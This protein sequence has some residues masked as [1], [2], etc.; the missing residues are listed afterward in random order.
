MKDNNLIN[1]SF[2]F[3]SC[4]CVE[5]IGSCAAYVTTACPHLHIIKGK[6]VTTKKECRKC[7]RR[8]ENHE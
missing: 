4:P 3:R 2:D 5:A 6:L 8:K 1:E 7:S